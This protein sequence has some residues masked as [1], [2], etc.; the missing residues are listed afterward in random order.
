[1][2]SVASCKFLLRIVNEKTNTVR[3]NLQE[4][5]TLVTTATDELITYPK[6]AMQQKYCKANNECWTQNDGTLIGSPVFSVQV[7]FLLQI[8]EE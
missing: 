5:T 4:G 7:E 6:L 2:F 1:M 3:H 8:L